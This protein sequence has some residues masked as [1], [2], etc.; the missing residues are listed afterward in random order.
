MGLV[1]SMKPSSG[2]T[3][4]YQ[5]PRGFGVQPIEFH[6]MRG[7]TELGTARLEQASIAE[8][9]E[10]VTLHDGALRRFAVFAAGKPDPHPGI[11]VLGGSE[12]RH[13]DPPKQHGL[14]RTDTPHSRWRIFGS[15]ICR[16]SW[17][18]FRSST[19]ARL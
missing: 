15:T 12:R 17:L 8:G 13:A 18:E 14:H 5:P 3:D 2:K 19:S 6:L 16:E 4:R 10:R 9:V 11:L 1:W 7:S